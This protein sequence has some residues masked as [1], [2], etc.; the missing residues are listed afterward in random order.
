MI[1]AKFTVKCDEC[2][3]TYTPTKEFKD[4]YYF[5]DYIRNKG[6][7]KFIDPKGEHWCKKCDME[8]SKKINALK[9]DLEKE[10]SRLHRLML[11][12]KS[13]WY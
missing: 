11:R 2:G 13:I 6:W 3:K 8:N 9:N 10:N 1:T 12:L 7:V 5:D 4:K